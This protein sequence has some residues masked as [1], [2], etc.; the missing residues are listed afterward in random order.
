MS[1]ESNIY[2]PE[3]L[4]RTAAAITRLG[5]RWRISDRK[6]A[7]LGIDRESIEAARGALRS[8]VHDSE[9]E[10]DNAAARTKHL[11]LEHIEKAKRIFEASTARFVMPI[12]QQE[13]ISAALDRRS[14]PV[15][16][17]LPS[18]SLA[19]AGVSLVVGAVGALVEATPVAEGGLAGSVLFIAIP[20]VDLLATKAKNKIQEIRSRGRRNS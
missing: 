18:V 16:V 3:D 7:R 10:Y 1:E 12:E 4:G 19:V 15:E 9:I 8:Q 2:T 6:L 5:G 17:D 20:A 11:R 14:Q 13:A